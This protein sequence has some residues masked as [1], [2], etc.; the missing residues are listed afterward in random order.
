MKYLITILLYLSIL[1]TI[2]A[3]YLQTKEI[4]NTENNE[5]ISARITIHVL[6]FIDEVTNI[7]ASCM[8]DE[9]LL[10][11]EIDK[12]GQI[13]G[14]PIKYY[15]G[16]F[17]KSGL[18]NTLSKLQCKNDDVVFFYYS[19]HGF[20]YN[21]QDDSKKY[22][23]MAFNSTR[24]DIVTS[25]MYSIEEVHRQI[26]NKKPRLTITIGDLCNSVIPFAL[27]ATAGITGESANYNRLFKKAKG[28]ILMTSSISGQ[29]SIATGKGSL[30]TRAMTLV[31]DENT[32]YVE[33]KY[34]SWEEILE[35]SIKKTKKLSDGRQ[36]PTG[37]VNVTYITRRTGTRAASLIMENNN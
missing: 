10:R 13:T 31:I 16:S 27:P 14:I 7:A 36:I 28:D 8:R 9:E 2:N 32:N 33:G 22:P 1:V 30:F 23:Y 11:H 6:M 24:N 5:T 35:K 29:V 37:E 4:E 20:R 19:G 25:T 15:K 12:A 18:I 34:A 26:I 3:Q 21:N 17:S